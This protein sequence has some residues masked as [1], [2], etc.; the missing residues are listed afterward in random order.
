MLV[1]V[2]KIICLI[3]SAFILIS[4]QLFGAGSEKSDSI[5]S[6]TMVE[7]GFYT[8]NYTYDYD[9]DKLLEE[10]VSSHVQLIFKGLCDA[11]FGGI[12]GLG[13][14]T[15]NSVT[16]GGDY[17]FGR[18]FDYTDSDYMLVWTDPEGGYASVSSVAL[19]F[20]GYDS[21][22]TPQSEDNRELTLLA[23]YAPLDGINEKGLSIAILELEKKPVFQTTEKVDLTT[24][25]IVR[26]VLDKAA[27]VDEAVEIFN[28]YDLRDFLLGGCTYHYQIAD[29]YGNSVVVEY[30]D[31]QMNLIHPETKTGSAVD[32]IVAANYFLTEG[33]DD[34]DGMG[35]ERADKVYAALNASRGITSESYA[36]QI[37][38]SVSM[39]DD[40]L[41]GYICSTLWSAVYNMNDLTADICVNNNYDR[42]YKFSLNQPQSILN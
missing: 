9:V 40:S 27:N 32:Y 2:R 37:L 41:H 39:K 31:G 11:A 29:A 18:N 35:Y 22:F 12:K 38:K 5:D 3:L 20:N 34:P 1:F 30:V 21:D 7:D 33:V 28:S 26:A 4:S 10:G 25:T 14:T 24:T 36:M 19:V 42:V 23:P 8:M 16:P 6:V 15:F 17:I 13:C